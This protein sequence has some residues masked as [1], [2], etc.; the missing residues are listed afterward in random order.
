M[1]VTKAIR[2]CP[3]TAKATTTTLKSLQTQ[4]NKYIIY[5]HSTKF[6]IRKMK[7]PSTQTS[8]TAFTHA[9]VP[10]CAGMR[11]SR[12]GLVAAF[13]RCRRARGQELPTAVPGCAEAHSLA[14]RGR[15]RG[16]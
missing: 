10:A 11:A 5:N 4:D 14:A 8:E 6:Y 3:Q 12:R 13:G 9:R 16:T 15:S 1:S 7:R 2:K